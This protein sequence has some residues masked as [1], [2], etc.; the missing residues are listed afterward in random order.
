MVVVPPKQPEE[1]SIEWF[2][3]KYKYTRVKIHKLKDNLTAYVTPYDYAPFYDL[4]N[5][6]S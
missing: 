2:T 1:H 5:S 4:R 6:S 3:M